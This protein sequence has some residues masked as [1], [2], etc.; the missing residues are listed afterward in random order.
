[1]NEIEKASFEFK[2]K[3]RDRK[4]GEEEK[5]FLVEK[6][7]LLLKECKE[8]Q[9]IMEGRKSNLSNDREAFNF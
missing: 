5:V 1:M 8:S 7:R 2:K 4:R 6:L 9:K 3:E